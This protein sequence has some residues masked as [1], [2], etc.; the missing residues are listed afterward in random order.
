MS[1]TGVI[2]SEING[3]YIKGRHISKLRLNKESEF[4]KIKT[5]IPRLIGKF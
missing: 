1:Q 5:K 2:I 4:V 3:T